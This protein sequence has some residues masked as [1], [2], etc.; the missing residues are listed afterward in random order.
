MTKYGAEKATEG[1]VQQ[2]IGRMQVYVIYLPRIFFDFL[3][4]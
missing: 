3:W 2:G 1:L 4:S